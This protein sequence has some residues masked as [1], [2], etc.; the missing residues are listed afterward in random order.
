L[1]IEDLTNQFEKMKKEFAQNYKG[2]SHIQEILPTYPTD[3]FEINSNDLKLLHNFVK[4]NPIYHN[5]YEEKISGIDCIVY[6][7]DIN[8]YWI[9]SL[10]H[11]TSAQPFYPTWM[12]S[13]YLVTSMAKHLGYTEIIDIGSGDGRIAFCGKV[14]GMDSI[15]IEI[16]DF[17]VNL[18]KKICESTKIKFDINCDDATEFDYFSLPLDTP[19]VFTGGLPQMGDVLTSEIIRKFLSKNLANSCCF[20]L[21]GSNTKKQFSINL[22]Y[23]GWDPLI[24]KFGL[25]VIKILNLPTVWTFD[26]PIN[27]PY[28]FVVLNS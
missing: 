28:V 14:L 4:S 10:K 3:T 6:E 12:M 22:P 21:A 9:N 17:L 7:G 26:Q 18:Q 24:K 5:F 13:A 19:A 8:Q 20:V 11:A 25:S 2:R 15:G 27:T 1:L 23:G 16:D